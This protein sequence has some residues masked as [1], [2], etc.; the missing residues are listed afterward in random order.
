MTD[1]YQGWTP[2]DIRHLLPQRRRCPET[3]S[4]LLYIGGEDVTQWLREMEIHWTYLYNKAMMQPM[5][6]LLFKREE[7]ATL[8]ALRWSS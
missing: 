8:F 4:E 1:D 2:V 7:D 6:I 5:P 3:F